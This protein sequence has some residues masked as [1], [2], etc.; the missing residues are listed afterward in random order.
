M[1]N[2]TPMIKQYLKIKS[3]NEDAFLFFRLGDFYELFFDDALK[4]A[5]ELEIT[6][7]QRDGGKEEKIP[8]CGVPYHSAENYISTLINKGY[9]VAICEQVEDPQASKGVVKREVVQVVTPGTIMED[10]MLAEDENNFITSIAQHEGNYIISY[11]DLSTGEC[12]VSKI[13]SFKDVLS[14]LYN[15][16]VKEVVVSSDFPEEHK[17]SLQ[18]YLNVTISFQDDCDIPEDFNYLIDQLNESVLSEA[19]GR[20]FQYI[21]HSQ[22]RFLTHLQRV[23][24]V[25]VEQFMKLDLYSKRNLELMESIRD[26]SQKGTLL[27]VLDQTS[28]AMGARRLKKWLDRPL[29]SKEAIERRHEQVQTLID[30]FFERGELREHLKNVY[31]LERLAGRVSYGNVNA[32]DLIQLKKSL[33]AVPHLK[34]ILNQFDSQLITQLLGDIH[35]YRDMHDLLEKSIHNEPPISITEGDIIKDGYDGKLDEYREASRNGKAWVAQLE[36]TE[37]EKTGIRSLKVGFNKVFG[38]YIEVTKANLSQVDTERYER[39]QTLAN[40]ERFI[41]PELKEKE[42]LILEAKDKSVALE[43]ELFVQIREQMKQYIPLLQKLAEQISEIDVLVSFANVSEQFNYVKPSL[44]EEHSLR[45]HE[46]RHPVVEQVMQEEFV[47]NSFEMDDDTSILL[48]TGPNMAGKST[49]MRQLGLMAIMAQIGCFVPAT[50]ANI[51]VFDQI[52]TRIGAA[53]DLVSGQS[54]FMV[55]MLEAQHAVSHATEN[56]LILF[57]EIGRGTSTYDGMA[58]AQS[59]VE[60]LHDQVGA[61]TLFATHYH[62]LTSLDESLVNLENVHV[63]VDEQEGEVVFLHTIKPGKADKSYGVHVAKLADLPDE[64][65]DRANYLLQTFESTQSIKDEFVKEQQLTL[66]E[67]QTEAPPAT[68][69]V[70]VAKELRETNLMNLTPMDAMNKLYELQKK[71]S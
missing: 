37:R 49:Y 68:K 50:Y 17:Q 61:K 65:I 10:N 29:L 32:R 43:Y 71:L 35:V 48:I 39:K 47:P 13:T 59:I 53:D 41:T 33:S 63:E 57:D 67:E 44:N 38:Y 42:R 2:Y 4:A 52:F 31:D 62:E 3:E 58:L 69:E 46:G 5:K 15:R 55:E 34:D 21:Y 14:E 11:T 6:L 9:K 20:L 19:F 25:P 1:G 12:F 8:M 36:A 26:K 27:S 45:I 51:P 23:E 24:Y 56:S 30:Y 28:T 18:A 64:I 16:P 66:F 22:K 54:T 60:H 7:T 40:A 70:E